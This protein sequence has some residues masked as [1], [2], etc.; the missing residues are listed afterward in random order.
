MSKR[1]GQI[2]NIKGSNRLITHLM[3]S[4]CLCQWSHHVVTENTNPVLSDLP[5]FRKKI[6]TYIFMCK[7]PNFKHWQPIIYY[8]LSFTIIYKT[9]HFI[10]K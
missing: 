1:S 6:H 3:A 10:N 2:I 8:L 9:Y 7:S 5:G 4:H